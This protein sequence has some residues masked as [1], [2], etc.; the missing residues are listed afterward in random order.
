MIFPKNQGSWGPKV[1]SL[2]FSQ[3][4]DLDLRFPPVTWDPKA[5]S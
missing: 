1:V 4:S 3:G 5:D 2:R